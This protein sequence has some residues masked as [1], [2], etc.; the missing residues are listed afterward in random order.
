M[1]TE[2]LREFMRNPTGSDSRAVGRIFG[3]GG[4]PKDI[5]DR[6][7]SASGLLAEGEDQDARELFRGAAFQGRL[8][9]E[10]SV[11]DDG[12]RVGLGMV[13]LILY[14][15]AHQAAIAKDF[16]QRLLADMSVPPDDKAR[17]SR[18][19]DFLNQHPEW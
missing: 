15:H 3:F 8:A 16:G 9:F 14:V 7:K 12:A 5:V 4:I 11:Q 19:L 17:I 1:V 6:A 13:T 10:T 2:A 18:Q